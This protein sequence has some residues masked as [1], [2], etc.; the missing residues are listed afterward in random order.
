MTFVLLVMSFT[1]CTKDDEFT[2]SLDKVEIE[3]YT[4]E[5]SKLTYNGGK[6]T[7]TSENPLIASVENGLVTAVHVGETV[8]KA[9]EASC[10]VIVKP[11]Y[12]KYYEPY[13]GFGGSIDQVKQHMK[14]Y[15][16]YQ[17]TDENL[18][19]IDRNTGIIYIYLFE[20]GALTSSMFSVEYSEMEY[21]LSFLLERYVP[22]S[23]E[24]TTFIFIS[25]DKSLGVGVEISTSYILIGYL[26]FSTEESTENIQK[27]FKK[28][29]ERF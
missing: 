13:I 29:K 7:W 23:Y 20:N 17:E 9:N 19:Y 15:E 6:C 8:V 24:G 14:D 12:N 1:A 11:R 3:L 26:P 4:D 28:M 2:P 21:L 10:K 25:P 22:V 27:S 18:A 16:L 5:T